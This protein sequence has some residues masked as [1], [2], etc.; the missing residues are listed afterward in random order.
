MISYAVLTVFLGVGVWF[1]YVFSGFPLTQFFIA[2]LCTGVYIL[3][4]ISHHI[5]EGDFHF[6]IVIEYILMSV[7]ALLL[8]YGAIF[9]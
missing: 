4:G 1:F 8:L 3:W 6:T 5:L 7:L 9:R 2:L